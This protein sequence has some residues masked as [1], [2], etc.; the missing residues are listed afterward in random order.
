M[1]RVNGFIKHFRILASQV[2]LQVSLGS[3]K[4]GFQGKLL[5][6][7]PLLTAIISLLYASLLSPTPFLLLSA[8]T[9]LRAVNHLNLSH[10]TENYSSSNN[11]GLNDAE[12]TPA[13]CQDLLQPW[14]PQVICSRFRIFHCRKEKPQCALEDLARSAVILTWDE[15]CTTPVIQ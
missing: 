6:L 5:A 8:K 7:K 4:W 12:A 2:L 9:L 10:S 15:R 3:W 1:A 14:L 11:Q 13:S